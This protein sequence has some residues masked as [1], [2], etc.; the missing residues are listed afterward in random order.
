MAD[1]LPPLKANPQKKSKLI[2]FRIDNEIYM[3]FLAQLQKEN[4][5]KSKKLRSFIKEYMEKSG[6][7]DVGSD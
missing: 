6:V 7:E 2:T 3:S 4:T 1:E 5:T